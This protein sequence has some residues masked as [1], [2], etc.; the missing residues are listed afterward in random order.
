LAGDRKTL[1]QISRPGERIGLL[2]TQVFNPFI[3][4]NYRSVRAEDVAYA[5]L[6]SVKSGTPGVQTLLSGALQGAA[7][8]A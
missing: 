1:N 4:A 6:K 8:T 7:G 3:P 2:V 5:L